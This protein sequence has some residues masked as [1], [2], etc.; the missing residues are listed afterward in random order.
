MNYIKSTLTSIALIASSFVNVANAGVIFFDD[1]EDGNLMNNPLY[2]SNASGVIVSDTLEGDNALSFL[3]SPPD[4][5]LE[6]ITMTSTTGNVFLSFDYLGTCDGLTNGC[7]GYMKLNE[8]GNGWIGTSG[9]GNNWGFNLIDDNT[10]N[11]Y[12]VSYAATTFTFILQDYFSVGDGIAGDAFFDN[13]RF[14]DT[15]F[16]TPPPAPIPEPMSLALFALGV[17]GLTARR[18]AK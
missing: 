7:G 10:W 6:S 8:S 11:H 1:F 16:E 14:S 9:I 2:A 17:F 15:G 18:F 12:E 3:P 4:S 13:I 5:Y